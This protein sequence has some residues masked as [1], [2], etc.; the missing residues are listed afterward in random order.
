MNRWGYSVRVDRLS[1]KF[2]IETFSMSLPTSLN[3]GDTTTFTLR[4]IDE[5]RLVSFIAF[6]MC[7]ASQCYFI[8]VEKS[9]S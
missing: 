7:I 4:P 9:N 6:N 3:S 5:F 2:A 8:R 1:I